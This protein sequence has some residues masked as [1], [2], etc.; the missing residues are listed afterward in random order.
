MSVNKN[1]KLQWVVKHKGSFKDEVDF[2]ETILIENGINQE[3]IPLFLNPSK[4][5]INDPFLLNNLN[6]AIEIV[7][8]VVKKDG[9]IFVKVDV[10]VDGFSS[11]STFIQ[12]IQAINPKVKI[13]YQLDYEKRHGLTFR[14]LTE[15]TR[16]EFDLIVIPDASMT[17]SDARQIAKNYTA[18]ILVLDHHL[19]ETEYLEIKTGKWISK[20][21]ADEISLTDENR[22]E[23]DVYTNYCIAVNCHDGNYPNPD[24]SGVGVVQ[25]FIEGYIQKYG[26]EDGI[27][28]VEIVKGSGIYE[29]LTTYFYDLVSTGMIADAISAKS[30]ETRYYMMEGMKPEYRHNRLLNEI[31]ERQEE[32][33]KFDRTLESIGWYLAPLINGVIRYG[34]DKEQEELFKA[35]LNID[36]T[37]EYQPRRK[38]RNDPIPDVETHTIQWDAARMSVNVKSRQDTA[39]RKNM[40]ELEDVIQKN[41]LDKNSII[42][43]DGTKVL[44]KGTIGGL[45]ANK[46]TNKYFRP[47]VLLREKDSFTYGG[48]GRGYDKGNIENFNEFLSNAGVTCLG[49][50]GLYTPFRFRQAG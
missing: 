25:K 26:K 10:D 15:Y 4:K 48:S 7:R 20:T 40:Q 45:I 12:F 22:I 38:S 41:G 43:V 19:I 23:E 34:K 35:I 42:F 33:F 44:E 37:V 39:V 28:G 32:N 6:E 18:K 11:A 3:D 9:N 8:D 30:P 31:V 16:D 36:E 27:N 47:V 5:S 50:I 1:E 21:E 17:C 24:L 46:L 2:L 29:D 13:K 49:Q 14:N